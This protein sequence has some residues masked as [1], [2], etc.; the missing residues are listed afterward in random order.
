MKIIILGAGQVG[1]SLAANLS[2][3]ANDITVVDHD[4]KTL[5]AL[6]DRL[7][8]NSVSGQASH[9]AVLRQAGADEAGDLEGRVGRWRAADGSN[10]RRHRLE[11]SVDGR[12][13][14]DQFAIRVCD[15]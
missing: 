14:L 2:T 10:H 11:R 9:P 8:I 7:D 6:R 12:T 3:E 1:S 4:E 13:W 5:R 15:F